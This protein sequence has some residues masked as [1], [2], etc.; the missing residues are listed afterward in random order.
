[1]YFQTQ[2]EV[3]SADT[4]VIFFACNFITF[5]QFYLPWVRTSPPSGPASLPILALKIYL[6]PSSPMQNQILHHQ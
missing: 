4:K 6:A 2:E 5:N 1:M 3:Y